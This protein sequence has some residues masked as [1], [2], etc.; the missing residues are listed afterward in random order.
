MIPFPEAPHGLSASALAK[1]PPFLL[2]APLAARFEAPEAGEPKEAIQRRVQRK[3]QEHE[4]E[5]REAVAAG[6]ATF[7]NKLVGV[8]LSCNGDTECT[9][10]QCLEQN[11]SKAMSWTKNSR[12]EFL[13]RTPSAAELKEVRGALAAGEKDPSADRFSAL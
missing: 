11:V 12:V 8:R 9:A 6:D 3:W 13:V 10:D 1:V 7:K 2:Y 5:A 4:S